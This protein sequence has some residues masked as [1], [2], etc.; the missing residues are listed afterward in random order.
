MTCQD[1]S[2][3]KRCTWESIEMSE[4]FGE[5]GPSHSWQ[6]FAL[7]EQMSLITILFP[8]WPGTKCQ[9]MPDIAWKN[10]VSLI[11]KIFTNWRL[12]SG[13]WIGWGPDMQTRKTKS[14]Q[15]GGARPTDREQGTDWVKDSPYE[16]LLSIL[17]F[18]DVFLPFSLFLTFCLLS[19]ELTLQ[20]RTIT[21]FD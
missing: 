5:Q 16:E 1:C 6:C 10:M 17:P 4:H 14:S 2:C 12:E 15:A 3:H 20:N 18:S 9:T 11:M 13:H 21:H 19:F 7:A 8:A